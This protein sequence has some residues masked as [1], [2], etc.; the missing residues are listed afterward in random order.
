MPILHK[1]M[2]VRTGPGCHIGPDRGVGTGAELGPGVVLLDRTRLPGKQIPA[3]VGAGA[4]VVGG[5]D[6]ILP[7]PVSI[8]MTVLSLLGVLPPLSG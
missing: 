5:T 6:P 3:T 4:K 7:G 8:A 1:A 2:A